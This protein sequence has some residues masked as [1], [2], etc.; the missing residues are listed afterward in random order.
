MSDKNEQ[1]DRWYVI[2]CVFIKWLKHLFTLFPVANCERYIRIYN[3]LW[4]AQYSDRKSVE[5][6]F[7]GQRSS[8]YLVPGN[9]MYS[10][11]LLHKNIYMIFSRLHETWWILSHSGARLR[12][13]A[14][15]SFPSTCPSARID[16]HQ[17]SRLFLICGFWLSKWCQHSRDWSIIQIFKARFGYQRNLTSLLLTAVL[18]VRMIFKY[19]GIVSNPIE[20]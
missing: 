11:L 17:W 10:C 18:A 3:R 16:Y 13:S 1:V 19:F 7:P 9:Q 20:W 6:Q 4:R 12:Y 8:L 15:S 2:D 14:R 5:L